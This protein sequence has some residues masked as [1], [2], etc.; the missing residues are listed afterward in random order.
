MTFYSYSQLLA[1]NNRLLLWRYGILVVLSLIAVL[2]LILFLRHRNDGKYRDLL[3]IFAL[4]ACLVGGIQFSNYQRYQT[5]L[6]QN[7]QIIR[8]L[9]TV[10]R[11][12]DV[13]LKKLKTNK[14]VLTD[15]MI[16]KMNHHYYQVNFDSDFSSYYLQRT[17]LI[18]DQEVK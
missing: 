17:Q 6:N 10:S 5:S 3:I 13:S 2:M 9:Q 14:T 11:K 15:K 4:S 18:G 8:F 1:Q 12:K 16:L 7:A